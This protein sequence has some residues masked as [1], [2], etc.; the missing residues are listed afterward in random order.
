MDS[1][2]SKELTYRKVPVSHPTYHL[3]QI[4]QQ[5]G[6]ADFVVTPSGGQESIFELPTKTFNLARSVLSFTATPTGPG[7]GRFN[8]AHI[9]GITFIRQI[10]LYTRTNEYL[11]DITDLNKYSNMTLRHTTKQSDLL[12]WDVVDGSNVGFFEGLTRNNTIIFDDVEGARPTVG[13]EAR[14]IN[15][16]SYV[17][18]GAAG[19]ATP[20]IDYQIPL[21]RIRDT[22]FSI[23]KDQYFGDTVYL[24]IVWAPSTT[25]FYNGAL[26]DNPSND[27]QPDTGGFTV[28]SLK[29]YAAIEQN[30]V[31][32]Q[33]LMNKVQAGTLTYQV[34]YIHSTR[35]TLASNSQNIS[36]RYN[37]AH[38]R[39]LK[40]I[41]WAPYNGTDTIN[42]SYDHEVTGKITDFYTMLNNVRTTQFNYVIANGLDWMDHKYCLTGSCINSSDEY[43][44]N[45]TFIQDFT[46]CDKESNTPDDESNTDDGY[47]LEDEV[48][49]DIVAITANNQ[50]NYY[51]FA[52]CMKDL[53]ISSA[54]IT[55][56]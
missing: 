15:E 50:H 30:N 52:V 34:P 41:Y 18:V 17:L 19:T 31:I 27:P 29:I 22:I 21:S 39:K 40:K 12:T 37:R 24:R 16:A 4:T 1:E 5:T 51:V 46:A 43:Y 6:S 45:W 14:S 48:K 23:D 36:V 47:I 32:N 7:A 8:Y 44:Y 35:T 20:T 25:T 38:G 33:E 10:Q 13:G 9:N 26:I 55:F 54:G 49:Y 28:S 53:T 3:S 56:R 42:N 11:C 2:V